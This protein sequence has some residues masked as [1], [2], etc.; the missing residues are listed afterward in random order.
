MSIST[1][2]KKDFK[3]SAN[4]KAKKSK[5]PGQVQKFDVRDDGVFS[6]DAN[7]NEIHICSKLEILARTRDEKSG[8]WGRLL[9]W[10]D[11]D[12]VTHVWA[13]PMDMLS[14]DGSEFRARLLQEGLDIK[15]NPK[16]KLALAA[17][18]QEFKPKQTLRCVTRIGWYGEAFVLPDEVFGGKGEITF[19][20]E[21]LGFH[22]FEAKGSLEDWRENIGEFC[23]GN[24]RLMFAVSAAFACP[25]LPIA[26]ITGGGFHFRGL[27]S[28]GKTT[29]LLVAGSVCGGSDEMLGYC[30]TWKSTGNG[31]EIVA[32]SHNNMLLCLDEIGECEPR[33]IG[34]I[35]YM[36]A[37]GQ[38]KN[39]MNRNTS[40]RKPYTWHLLFISTG[41]RKLSDIMLEAGQIARGGQE[42]RLCDIDADTGNFGIFEN[43][44][45][46]KDGREFSDYL[47]ESSRQFYGTPI[48]AFLQ[49][50]VGYSHESIKEQ[51]NKFQAEFIKAA[52]EGKENQ[53]GEVLRVASRFALVAFAGELAAQAEITGWEKTEATEAALKV[54]AVWL[55]GRTGRGGSD[56]EKILSQVRNFLNL[57]GQ[58]RFQ[59]LAASEIGTEKIINHVGYKRKDAHGE[60]EYLI[61]PEAFTNEACK[62]FDSTLAA[63]VLDQRGFLEKGSDGKFSKSEK[64]GGKKA[65]RMYVINSKIFDDESSVYENAV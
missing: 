12:K 57:H 51:W 61:F 55:E 26:E 65:R 4:G 45:G 36:L 7:G 10:Q 21:H 19:Q 17:Y 62:G 20:S 49:K 42:I 64:L 34:N 59:W 53:P 43:I 33:E 35:A 15:Q 18:I 58:S 6:F 1:A 5:A 23:S 47:R 46:F 32:E 22:K 24:S 50:I 60:I 41:E 28:S 27:T 29:A 25:L 13:M 11:P 54:F 63:R 2:L 38:G 37:N 44:Y 14:G 52:L 56:A 8:N 16:A 39:R 3:Q 48:R 40:R 9:Q 30:Q 31:L